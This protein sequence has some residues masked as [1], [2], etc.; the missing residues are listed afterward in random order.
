MSNQFKMAG[1]LTIAP[2]TARYKEMAYKLIS[3]IIT[4]ARMYHY[5]WK[6]LSNT[7][8]DMMVSMTVL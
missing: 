1:E 5:V 4:I 3:Q 7:C 8:L 6:D 2:Y